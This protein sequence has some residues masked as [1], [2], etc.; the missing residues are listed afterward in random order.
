MLRK[1]SSKTLVTLEKEDV[2]IEPNWNL[3]FKFDPT[4]EEL[5]QAA[6]IFAASCWSLSS[7]E[8]VSTVQRE[9]GSYDVRTGQDVPGEEGDN[10]WLVTDGEHRAWV[11]RYGLNQVP[12]W[13]VN[14]E[15]EEES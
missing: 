4:P 6:R 13:S 1:E 3:L 15:D 11:T 2:R 10:T 9:P 7:T 8:N 5:E 14:V 12:L